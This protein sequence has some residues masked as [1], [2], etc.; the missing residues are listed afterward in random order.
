MSV[1]QPTLDIPI[2]ILAGL[3]DGSYKRF[4]GVIRNADNGQ[5]VTMLRDS[6]GVQSLVNQGSPLSTLPLQLVAPYLQL[7]NLGVSA[8]GFTLVIQKLEQLGQQIRAIEEKV[9]QVAFKLDDMSW[10][11]LKAGIQ[12]SCDAVNLPDPALR[13]H[14]VAQAL[15]TLHES[16]QYFNQQAIRAIQKAEAASPQY[17]GLVMAALVAE[18]QV[19]IHLDETE[20]AAQTLQEGLEVLQPA[21]AQLLE[22]VL[23]QRAFYLRPEFKDKIGLDL[24][25]WLQ[26]AHDRLSQ[27]FGT[28]DVEPITAAE[29]FDL[30]REDLA[31]ALSSSHNW[32]QKVLPALVDIRQVEDWRFMFINTGTNQQKLQEL[33]YQELPDGLLRIAALV[34]AY[35]RLCGQWLQLTAM[36]ELRLPPSALEQLSLTPDGPA[37]AIVLDDR[38]LDPIAA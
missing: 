2:K 22:S 10:A 38:L 32:C 37:A 18:M 30:V 16:R 11:K 1:I 4:G 7:A 27:P 20:R 17:L 19:Y 33:T 3:A 8:I 24:V 5:I 23:Q 28:M 9:E 12:A 6:S 31:D 35:D 21:L 15:F 34:E 13:I 26:S 25:A 14:R 36:Q 29:L